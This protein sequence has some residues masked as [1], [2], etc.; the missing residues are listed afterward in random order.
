MLAL[1][2]GDVIGDTHIVDGETIVRVGPRSAQSLDQ[3]REC[4]ISDVRAAEHIS[5]RVHNS[6]RLSVVG[7]WEATV[8]RRSAGLP[9]SATV[10]ETGNEPGISGGSLGHDLVV[11]CY[12][13]AALSEGT[14]RTVVEKVN[15]FDPEQRIVQKG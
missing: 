7:K 10:D 6:V 3:D 1:S 4:D 14:G 9:E 12:D 13:R 5:Y 8:V 2:L 11:R 15:D